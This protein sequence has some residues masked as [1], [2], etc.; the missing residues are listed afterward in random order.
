MFHEDIKYLVYLY[1]LS[2]KLKIAERRFTNKTNMKSLN[3]ALIAVIMLSMIAMPFAMAAGAQTGSADAGTGSNESGQGL[4][5][6]TELSTQN[7][8]EASQ[9][10][11]QV[12]AQT[13]TYMNQA[14]Q[15]M[16]IQTGEG[17]EV[18]LQSGNLEAKTTMTMT[19]EQV[20]NRTKLQVML[21][22]GMN[23]EVKVMPDTAS[24]TALARLGAKCE[25][26]CTIELKEVGTGN[27]VKAAYEI[28]TQKQA[29]VLGLF[30]AKMQV[31]AQVDAENGE[32]IQTK[33]PWWAFLATE[34]A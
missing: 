3:I 14:G 33:K 23:A 30:Q 27:Q 2:C 20:Q 12:Q 6:N 28:K 13:G 15:Q 24:E 1:K 21:S 8:G 31:Q 19:Q 32:V 7:Q 5:V 17:N 26:N 4:E 25:G 34:T 10:Q 16:Q 9:L 18:K 11:N 29:K 22:N